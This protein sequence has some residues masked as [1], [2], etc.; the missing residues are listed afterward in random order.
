MKI[1]SFLGIR[2]TSPARSIPNNALWDAADV[3]IDDAGALLARPGYAQALP[4]PVDAA[5]QCR[6]GDAYLVGGGQLR[7]VT[8][9]LG[10]I[11]ICP[12]RATAFT[13]QD[14]YLWTDDGWQVYQGAAANIKLPVPA[15]PQVQVVAGNRPAGWY[16]VVTTQVAPDGLMSPASAVVEVKLDTPGDFLVQADTAPGFTPRIWLTDG[17]G[18]PTAGGEVFYDAQG[19]V[20]DA[21]YLSADGFPDGAERIEWHDGRLCVS[22]YHDGHGYIYYSGKHRYHLWDKAGGYCVIPG[23]V[24]DMRSTGE[25]LIVATA[26]HIYAT[27]LS[28]LDTLAHYGVNPGDAL[29]RH[30]GNGRVY[31][32]SL[33][34]LCVALPFDN[35]TEKKCSLPLGGHASAHFM[36]RHGAEY[37]I[38]LHDGGDAQPTGSGRAFNDYRDNQI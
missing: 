17:L 38:T 14:G 22:V 21:A 16:H 29:R 37:F 32:A 35:L 26:T 2:N 13:D 31:I 1:D 7:Q 8:A 10:L 34:G 33:R 23:R 24:L 3:D 27:D 11:G 5:Y 18:D 28:N 15:A 30:P 25:R 4:V 20:L 36:H 12:S 6:N 9:D 19:N